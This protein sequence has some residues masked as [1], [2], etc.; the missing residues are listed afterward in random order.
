VSTPVPADGRWAAAA[1]ENPVRRESHGSGDSQR[2]AGGHARHTLGGVLEDV[3]MLL[4]VILLIPL[5][6]L[7]VGLPVVLLVRVVLEIAQRM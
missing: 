1:A 6:I 2:R 3:V 4:V 5:A 7:L